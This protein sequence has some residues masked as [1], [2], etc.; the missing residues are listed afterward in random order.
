ME[1]ID[2]FE[3]QKVERD[4]KEYFIHKLP[5]WDKRTWNEFCKDVDDNNDNIQEQIEITKEQ[6]ET[7]IK[8]SYNMMVDFEMGQEERG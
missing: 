1:F 5:P 3:K 8:N 4:K 7:T 2:T 6:L